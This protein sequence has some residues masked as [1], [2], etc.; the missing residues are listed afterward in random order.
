M[1]EPLVVAE[2]FP[3]DRDDHALRDRIARKFCER[4]NSGGSVVCQMGYDAAD[5]ALVVL[6]EVK[7]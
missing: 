4:H 7:R 1:T 2:Q 5:A 6:G 3:T